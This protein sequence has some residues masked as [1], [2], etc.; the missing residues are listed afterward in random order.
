MIDDLLKT[1]WVETPRVK[2]DWIVVNSD[3]SEPIVS[4]KT[5]IDNILTW[6]FKFDASFFLE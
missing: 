6:E 2:I 4:S 5:E 3:F 1:S